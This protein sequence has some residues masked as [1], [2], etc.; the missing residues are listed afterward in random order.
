[1]QRY[2]MRQE[3]VK[4]II[5]I[6]MNSPLYLT[7]SVRERYGLVLQLIHDYPLLTGKGDTNLKGSSEQQDRFAVVN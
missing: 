4:E 3:D 2:M 5:S 6:L 1:M 7:L